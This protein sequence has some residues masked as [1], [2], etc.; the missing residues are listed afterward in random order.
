MDWQIDRQTE[1]ETDGQTDRQT[2]RHMDGGGRERL[3][4]GRRDREMVKQIEK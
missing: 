3:M 2:D 1:L 4:D